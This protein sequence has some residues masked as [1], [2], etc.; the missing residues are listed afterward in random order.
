MKKETWHEKLKTCN[1][2]DFKFTTVS[3]LPIKPLYTPNDIKDFNY[4]KDLG[5]PGEFPYTRGVQ[6]NMYR[7]R[8]WTM[9]Q[10]SGFGAPKDTN[11]R[12]KYLLKH[13]QTGLSVAFDFPTLYG[14]DSD[15]PFAHGEVGKCAANINADAV[16]HHV[17]SE[18]LAT[19]RC[20]R[21]SSVLSW[22]T[23]KSKFS[24]EPVRITP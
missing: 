16:I 23:A 12:Y 22:S 11:K 13:G 5:Y 15:D 10:F 21:R 17:R 18:V 4:E 24:M 9:R 1:E 6:A 20:L 8:L 7:G 2:R 14:R 3:G 19:R